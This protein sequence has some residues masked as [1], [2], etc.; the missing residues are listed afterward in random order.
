M[1]CRCLAQHKCVC[2]FR[3][4]SIMTMSSCRIIGLREK[5]LTH[6]RLYLRYRYI[7]DSLQLVYLPDTGFY[8]Y[9][10][11]TATTYAVCSLYIVNSFVFV[12]LY[13]ICIYY[14]CLVRESGDRLI[15]EQS[16]INF[17]VC[18]PF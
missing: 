12:Y 15:H 7:F 5:I 4:Y 2:N 17:T 1:T 14:Y 3:I 6:N 9:A 13:I 8:R 16:V 18:K 11:N 10:P